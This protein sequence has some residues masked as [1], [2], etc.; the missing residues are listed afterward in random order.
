M[1]YAPKK[2]KLSGDGIPGESFIV[3]EYHLDTNH[4]V[5]MPPF[6]GTN[7]VKK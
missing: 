6:G 4:H 7:E 5:P 2:I 3:K 1:D